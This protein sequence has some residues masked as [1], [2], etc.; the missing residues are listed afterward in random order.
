MLM[1]RYSTKPTNLSHYLHRLP[2]LLLIGFVAI[3]KTAFSGEQLPQSPARP[4]VLVIVADDWS[5]HAGA[6]GD[7]VVPTPAIDRL[8]R[9][10][11]LF[12]NAFCAAPSC[13]PSRAAMLTGRYPHQLEEGGNLWGT[14]PATYSNY[15]VL[16]EKNGYKIGLQ[17]KGWGPGNHTV[18]GYGHNPA[19]PAFNSFQTFLAEL[20]AQTPFCFWIGSSDPH[21]PYSPELKATAA[22]NAAAL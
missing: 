8:A 20:P 14:L 18:G 7:K 2:G 5:P 12:E 15:T 21:R 3:A 16:L 10:G 11:V 1:R 6:Y 9:E 22:L 13:S 19:G 4:N 17:G